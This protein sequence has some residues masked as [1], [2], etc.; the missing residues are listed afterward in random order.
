MTHALIA[1]I[2]VLL[3]IIAFLSR[4]IILRIRIYDL[5]VNKHA[6]EH[7]RFNLD[8]FTANYG[9]AELE[10]YRQAIK[11]AGVWD[12]FIEAYN[13][14]NGNLAGDESPTNP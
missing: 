5:T 14:L 2:A 4:E 13:E 8:R 9:I 12:E 3:T 1:T 10:R 6:E 7:N 11:R